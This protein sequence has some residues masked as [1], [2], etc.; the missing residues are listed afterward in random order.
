MN[1]S[2][3]DRKVSVSGSGVSVELSGE[4]GWVEWVGSPDDGDEKLTAVLTLAGRVDASWPEAGQLLLDGR[5]FR[6]WV[7]RGAR[8]LTLTAVGGASFDGWLSQY[9]ACRP[10]PSPSLWVVQA[11]TVS[12]GGTESSKGPT[13]RKAAAVR[14][15]DTTQGDLTVTIEQSDGT[16]MS[17]YVVGPAA[18]AAPVPDVEKTAAAGSPMGDGPTRVKLANQSGADVDAVI[19]WRCEL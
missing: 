19:W 15:T 14:M 3:C 17:Q 5:Q 2:N 18:A 7:P 10:F 11:L 9:P 4:A 8:M 16:V 6:I 13:R 12:N 1:Y